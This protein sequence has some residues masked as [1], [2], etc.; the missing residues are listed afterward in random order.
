VK[1]EMEAALAGFS[2]TTL[3]DAL[4][5]LG[6]NGGC[7]R[8]MP[9]TPG[10]R[11]VGPAFTA[12]FEPVAPGELA[13]AADYIDDVPAGAVV[14]ID[15]GGLTHCTVWG[16]ILSSCAL[17]RGVAGTVIHGLCRDNAASRAMGYPLFALGAYM[18]S[19]KNRV[20][21][22][23]RNVSVT[24]GVTTVE[25]GDCVFADDDGVLVV[26]AGHLQATI[27]AARRILEME[28][29]VR[30]AMAGGMRLAEA[31]KLHGYN[32]FALRKAV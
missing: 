24:I 25:P 22:T 16:D 26:P 29:R 19:G 17:K 8:I 15:N 3:S 13:A 18:K 28:E 1:S 30:E 7:G 32:A 6:V 12:K 2:S 27:E 23:A 14:V 31:R 21:M 4:D 9:M 11:C 10:S 5:T 20:R